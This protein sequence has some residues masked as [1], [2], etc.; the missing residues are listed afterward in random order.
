MN[1]RLIFSVLT[2]KQKCPVDALESPTTHFQ[3]LV[4]G[5][6]HP[7][8]NERLK[9][10]FRILPTRSNLAD[11][12]L[13]LFEYIDGFYNVKRLHSAIHFLSPND[14]ESKFFSSL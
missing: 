2:I 11:L 13:S 4:R 6:T 1:F 9:I 12:Q 5:F 7:S 8:L 10:D 3:G 14:F